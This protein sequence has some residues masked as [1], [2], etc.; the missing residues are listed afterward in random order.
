MQIDYNIL[1]AYGGFA[2]KFEKGSIIFHEGCDPYFF[3]Q[4]VEGEVK[5]YS[6]NA[7]GRELIQGIFKA[8]ESFGEPPLMLGKKYP[9]TAQAV[10]ASVIVKISLEK[11]SAI[12]KDYPDIASRLLFC[13]AE[14]IYNKSTAAQIWISQTPEEKIVHFLNKLK[15]INK[16]GC[17]NLV[18][19]TRQQIADCTGLRVETVIRTLV[20]MKKEDK[21]SIVDRKVYY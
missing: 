15:E 14:R 7:E 1:I 4:V 3:Y 17:R 16:N 9:S 6:S 8:G 13:F 2:R 21:V 10:T 5:L 12:L 20:R 19:Y 11:F 18:P